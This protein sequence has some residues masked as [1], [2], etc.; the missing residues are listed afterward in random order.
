MVLFYGEVLCI[1]I[2]GAASALG[3]Y[4]VMRDRPAVA[5]AGKYVFGAA[6][7]VHSAVIGFESVR[8]AGT[9][10]SGPNIVMLASWVL[11]VVSAVGLAVTKRGMSL[12]AVSALI[13]AAL[14]AASQWM[15]ILDPTAADNMAFYQ[16][17]LLVP[18]IVLVFLACAFFATSAVASGIQ[19]YQRRLMRQRSAKVL[20]LD[21]P[22]LDTL[23]K[24]A[25]FTALA[26][27]VMF[28][29]ALLIG[30]THLVA[31]YAAMVR[32]GC[33]GSL[34]YLAPRI[35]LSVVVW[36]AW[37]AYAVLAFLAPYAV[38]SRVRSWLAI[39]SFGLAVVLV[40]VSAG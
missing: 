22:A 27:L 15:R 38:G 8:T 1:L 12:A 31:I 19:L 4:G 20:T 23:G 32:V 35:G 24:I 9:L 34:G 6:L 14:I 29:A 40:A 2:Y 28:S 30:I 7:L 16:W 39:A 37:A 17:P 36:L 11:A 13:V 18:H 10:L 33:E 26:G 25:R 21:T 3:L 5:R